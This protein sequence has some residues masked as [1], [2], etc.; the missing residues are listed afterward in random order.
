MRHVQVLLATLGIFEVLR[1]GFWEVSRGNVNAPRNAS[2][3]RRSGRPTPPRQA[4]R[5]ARTW[6]PGTRPAWL[7]P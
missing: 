6:L 3:L 2:Y 1:T 7:S 4:R 5:T